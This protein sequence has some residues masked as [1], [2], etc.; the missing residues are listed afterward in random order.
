MELVLSWSLLIIRFCGGKTFLADKIF[1]EQFAKK[2][3]RELLAKP[4]FARV[5]GEQLS[6]EYIAKYLA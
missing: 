1:G 2:I 5:R 6:A 4:V 3:R